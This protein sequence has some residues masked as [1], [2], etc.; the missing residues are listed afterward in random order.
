MCI[1]RAMLAGY[2]CF[3]KVWRDMA[4]DIVIDSRG[5]LF[6]VEVKGSAVG[7]F[8]ATRGARSGVQINRA[9]VRARPLRREDCDLLVAVSTRDGT[10][11]VVPIDVIEIVR[12]KTLSFL[13]LTPFCEAWG[14]LEGEAP[15]MKW[16]GINRS[17][18]RDGLRRHNNRA[19][20]ELIRSITVGGVTLASARPARLTSSIRAL[21]LSMTKKD[22]LIL[23]AWTLMAASLRATRPHK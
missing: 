13:F 7:K 21:Y 8:Q 9:E 2:M 14:L 15:A 18:I 20:E 11:Y 5:V 10:C 22:R 16:K 6:R 17:V 1:S 19:L 3:F 4:Y 12:R 23:D